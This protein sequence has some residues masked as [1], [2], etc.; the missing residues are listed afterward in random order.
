MRR[1]RWS[2]YENRSYGNGSYEKFSMTVAFRM[3]GTLE[4]PDTGRLWDYGA[5]GVLEDGDSVVAYFDAPVALPFEGLWEEADTKDW[6][7]EYHRTLTSI[8]VGRL[9]VAPTHHPVTLSAGQRALWLDPGMAFGSG[10][11]ETTYLALAALEAV[12]LQGQRVL[13]V[14][15]GSGILA[16]A[17]DLL[18]AEGAEG[19]DIDPE[20]VPVAQGNAKLNLSRAHFSVA[21][22]SRAVPPADVLV[23]NLFA[24]LH[25]ELAP[26]Y[27]DALKPGGLLLAT[28]ILET[29]REVAQDAL[30]QYFGEVEVEVRGEWLLLRARKGKAA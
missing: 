27:R 2:Q 26:A 7:A 13:D 22:L 3:R 8:S 17:A 5:T 25:A 18:G 15:A 20:T 12:D 14:G 9:V 11:H 30:A 24:E 4:H 19:L 28:G 29:R 6:V 21:T 10:H 23:A 16:I 1:L